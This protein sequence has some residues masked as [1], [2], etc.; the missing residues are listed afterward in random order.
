MELVIYGAIVAILSGG[1]FSFFAANNSL[2]SRNRAM[3][4]VDTEGREIMR[5]L[6][7]SLRNAVSVNTP[8]Q[9]T[10]SSSLSLQTDVSA[11]NPT[12][13]DVSGGVL[14]I[15]EGAG[16]TI[17]VS[18]NMVEITNVSF[19]NLGFSGGLS[20]IA[21]QFNVRFLNSYNREELRYEKTF[22]GSA[23]LR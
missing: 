13:F 7:Q 15:Q 14:R 19:Q 17:P 23:T 9:G 11:S 8:I 2:N 20:S 16:G 12:V 4:E 22:Y 6:T 10:S 5:V 21:V 3:Y 18:G 1:V